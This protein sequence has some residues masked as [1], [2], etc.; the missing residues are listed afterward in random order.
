MMMSALKMGGMDL[1]TDNKRTADPN[2]PKGYYEF[3]RVKKLPKDDI[4][5]LELAKGKAVKII[6]ALLRYLPQE[7]EYR[8]IF[9]ERDMEE[10]LASQDRMLERSGKKREQPFENDAIKVSFKEHLHDLKNWLA[11]QSWIDTLYVSYNNILQD[12][13][14]EFTKI[15]KFLDD[16]V[17]PNAMVSVVDP[18][19]YR[20]QNL[21]KGERSG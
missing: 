13:E 5:W 1:V 8:V 17:D 15:S 9:M 6:S 18:T 10:I 12:P 11:E 20:E 16:R 3:E 21:K 2:N 14:V 7:F 19:L 4:A